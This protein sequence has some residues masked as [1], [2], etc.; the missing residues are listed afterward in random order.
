MENYGQQKYPIAE[1]FTAPQGEGKH[2]G[3]LM[4]FI[5]LA[6][7]T[8]GTRYP[9]QEYNNDGN[10]SGLFPIYTNECHL[11]DGRTFACDTDY[12]KKKALS[13][14]ELVAEV[15]AGGALTVCISGGEPLIHDIFPLVKLLA[16]CNY[17]VHLETSGTILLTPNIVQAF[18]KMTHIAISPKL[19]FRD[20]YAKF[21]H[22][23]K[24]LVDE[25]FNWEAVPAILKTNKNMYFQPINGEH[26][27][28]EENLNLC[29]KLQQEH[30][31]VSLSLQAHKFWKT[32]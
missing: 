28:S 16:Q 10:H 24:L 21:A 8:V 31:H 17:Q 19:G 2:V 26:T 1:V 11:F 25:N 7:C 32:R 27:I 9:A 29:L 14:W 30:P 12:V 23:V 3:R 4:C 18:M 6:G 15:K 20:E 5:R 13:V 22:E